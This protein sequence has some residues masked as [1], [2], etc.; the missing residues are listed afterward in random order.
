M[1]AS[2]IP[3]PTPAELWAA[4]EWAHA[5]GSDRELTVAF[6]DYFREAALR[7]SALAGVPISE[8]AADVIA[9]NVAMALTELRQ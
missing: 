2:P 7:H 3:A 1:S 6:R 9:N 4:L 8:K 5:E